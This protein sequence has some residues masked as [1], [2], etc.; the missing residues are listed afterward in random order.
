MSISK[1][2][3]TKN[4]IICNKEF[5]LSYNQ[6]LRFKKDNNVQ[7]VCSKKCKAIWDKDV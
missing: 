7:F 5:E 2:I 4:C 1:Q 6:K 3:I